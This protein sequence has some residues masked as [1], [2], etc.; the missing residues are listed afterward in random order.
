MLL[1]PVEHFKKDKSLCPK[2]YHGTRVEK[3]QYKDMADAL[4]QLLQLPDIIPAEHTK[5]KNIIN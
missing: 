3:L 1:L 4:Y 2:T 5:V